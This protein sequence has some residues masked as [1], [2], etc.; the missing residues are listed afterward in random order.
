[1]AHDS[2]LDGYISRTPETDQ[3]L[4]VVLGVA[5]GGLV[6]GAAA[7][8]LWPE[9]AATTGLWAHLQYMSGADGGDLVQ[10]WRT[11]KG[12]G[13]AWRAVGALAAG[14]IA[15][16]AAAAS[17]IYA[18]WP[19]RRRTL[20]RHVRGPELAAG[21]KAEKIGRRMAKAEGFPGV[22]IHPG[23]PL[24]LARETQ[25]AIYAGTTGSGKTQ[26]F[27]QLLNEIRARTPD[28]RIMIH[29][30]KGDYTESAPTGGGVALIGPTDARSVPW[31]IA[32]DIRTELDA[33]LVAQVVV[34][35]TQDP[36][37]SVAARLV[38][39]GMCLHCIKAHGREWGWPE[40]AAL[41]TLPADE[42][43]RV[44]TEAHPIIGMRLVPGKTTDSILITAVAYLSWIRHLAAAWPKSRGAFSV[45]RWAA[46]KSRWR[47]IIFQ[48]R[49]D[50]ASLV[51]PLIGAIVS[52]ASRRLLSLPDSKSREVWLLLDEFAALPRMDALPPLLERGR[53]K[54][55]RVV[56]AY[57][58]Y[59][60]VITRY[61]R[62]GTETIEALCG[63][64]VFFR[65]PTGSTARHISEQIGETEDEIP[66]PTTQQQGDTSITMQRRTEPLVRP[67]EVS[68]L[69]QPQAEGGVP[70]YLVVS[71]WS[72]VLRLT[73][74]FVDVPR[75][76]APYKPARWSAGIDLSAAAAQAEIAAA[77]RRAAERAAAAEQRQI[78]PIIEHQPQPAHGTEPE[79][80]HDEPGADASMQSI[81]ETIAHAAPAIAP[82][83]MAADLIEAVA[84]VATP[85]PAADLL[86]APA[87]SPAR[88]SKKR[89]LAE[90]MLAGLSE[91]HDL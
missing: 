11:V 27:M 9:P 43:Q 61:G 54:G 76:R 18:T 25:H 63:V 8:A 69:P 82:V 35:D 13:V 75:L 90:R 53:S 1:M 58:S 79:A 48:H 81:T 55:V 72:H 31:D 2:Y 46:G 41:L 91:E 62:E 38:F 10:W 7:H 33:E 68:G 22:R 34:Q 5:V 49:D 47:T 87:Q 23:V 74:P 36:F 14:G 66:Q 78:L 52:L 20:I 83:L 85:T 65:V 45:T 12:Q 67:E 26:G 24:P 28:A 70:G 88:K 4:S 84:P 73:W 17:S 37:W 21:R 89:R 50:A 60:Q 29:D 42:Q 80:Q 51:Q 57:Q 16:I 86:P 6:A 71:G 56:L 15:G 40:L 19:R 64:S 44:L 59:S 32:S 30:T 3:P 77:H 39:V